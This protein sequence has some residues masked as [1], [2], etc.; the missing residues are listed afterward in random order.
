[1]LNFRKLKQDFS[2]S[3]LKEGKELFE[4]ENGISAKII[5]LDSGTIRLAAKVQGT[6]ENTY[7]CEFEIDRNESAAVDSN[8]DCTYTYDCQ[9]IAALI[10]YLEKHLNKIV[11]NYSKE[12]DDPLEKLEEEEKEE[13]QKTIEE[14]VTK[15]KERYGHAFQKEILAEYIQAAKVL[16]SSPFFL[17]ED[18]LEEDHAQ[19]AVIFIG[20]DLE[21]FTAENPIQIQLVL[22]LPSRSKPLSLPN[23]KAFIDAVKYHEPIK[24]SGKKYLFT[25]RSFS[26]NEWEILK[27]IADHAKFYGSPEEK[28]LRVA[29]L[30][31]EILGAILAKSYEFV[32]GS[33]PPLGRIKESLP[34]PSLY[35]G[36]L[37]EPVCFATIPA[38][39]EFEIDTIETPAPTML[40]KPMI[41]LDDINVSPGEGILFESTRPGIIY[42]NTYYRFL[43]KIHRIHLREIKAFEHCTIPE[44]L[45]GTFIENGM[46]VLRSYAT[47]KNPGKIKKI[48][49]LPYVEPLKAKCKMHYLNGELE[50]SFYFLYGDAEVPA[51]FS[52][53]KYNHLSLFET[54]DGILARNLVEEKKL[55]EAIFQDF[56]YNETE[57]LFKVKSEKKIVEFM[58]EIIPK[59]SDRV[60]FDCPENLSEQFIYDE[61]SFELRLKEGKMISHYEVDFKVN[62]YLEGVAVDRL[63][64]CLAANK[65]YLELSSQ[66]A[67]SKRGK[68]GKLPRILVLDLEKLGPIV[69]LFDEIGIKTLSTH[70]SS[71]PLWS[72]TTLTPDQFKGL[73][74]KFSL[75][76]KLREIQKQMMGDKPMHASEIPSQINASLRNYQIE[77]VKWL[78]RIRTMYLGGILADDM[79]LGKTVQAITAITQAMREDKRSLS[80]VV[81]PTSLVYNWK[82]EF[83]KFNPSLKVLV[84]DGVPQTRK[85]LIKSA[86]EDDVL[87]TSYNLLQK[88]IETYEEY[89]F[90]YV[91]LDE[92]QHIKNRGTRNA[93][94][95]KQIRATHKLILTGTPIE[96]SLEELW[97]LFDFLMPGLLS[98]Y[99]RFVEKYI[100]NCGV[101]SS[102]EVT[103]LENLRKKIGP[104]ILRRMKEDVLDDLPPVSEIVYHCHLSD[105]QKKL[106][107]SYAASAKEELSRLV[108]KEGFDKV[109]IHVLATLTRLKQI[110]CHPAIF[111]KEAVEEGDS[112]KYDMLIELLL[113][114]IESGHKT[115]IFSQYT[116]ML[117]IMRDDLQTRGIKFSYLDGSSKNRIQIV[118]K[119]N[120]SSE[121]PVF[122]VSLKAGGSGLNLVGAD[123]VI[124][125]DMWWNPAVENQATDR[126]HRIGQTRSVSSY[127]LITLDTIEEKILSLQNRKKELVKKVVSCD[128]EAYTKLTWEEVLELLQV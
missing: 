100:R 92:A 40:L 3:V 75:S 4:K 54:K 108:Q 16:G 79:G 23:L 80:L 64:E 118:N 101:Y 128:D 18:P 125:Y 66:N 105:E 62:G 55:L 29:E 27:L 114:L 44:P 56:V 127:K 12:T 95:V 97:S 69:Q 68:G 113:S 67:A 90:N 37:E 14:A 25:P 123:T 99:D 34:L 96:N 110:C 41:V 93:K 116:R 73:P 102:Q 83:S 43:D 24:I 121:I 115:V 107:Q 94:S 57:G 124:H 15:E 126:V 46:P 21:I 87:I 2:S 78:E 109:Q 45:F 86:K 72:L 28:Y 17:P 117:S 33:S 50:A 119:F 19:L 77:G 35:C 9:H 20:N 51:A 70:R 85:K 48:V 65:T 1:M 7:E 47:V 38:K 22:R 106:Y 103:N 13:L 81:C 88:D 63:W 49:T 52:E 36:N 122:L 32:T 26:S 59:Y 111:A 10:F 82:E 11:V 31:K 120:E 89:T 98:S 58:T 84:V 30:D 61:T 74:V 5:Y 53:L 76:S 71:S 112:A 8:C 6:F 42:Q 91:I 60:D 104:F 39:I